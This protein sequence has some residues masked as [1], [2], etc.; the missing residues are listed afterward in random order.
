MN[1]IKEKYE[2]NGVTY[3]TR[4]E[5]ELVKKA[6]DENMSRAERFFTLNKYLI[7]TQTK[8]KS[9]QINDKYRSDTYFLCG[10][11]D[12]DTLVVKHVTQ[13]VDHRN[14]VATYKIKKETKTVDEIEQYIKKGMSTLTNTS[15]NVKEHTRIIGY[16]FSRL[17]DYTL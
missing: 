8:V 5:A 3:N 9:E 16:A 17:I 11:N 13:I 2:Y 7:L 10:V 12:A 15:E 4:A 14:G 1:T 6:D